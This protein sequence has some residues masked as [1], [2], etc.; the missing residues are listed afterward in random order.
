MGLGVRIAG[1]GSYLPGAPVDNAVHFAHAQGAIAPEWVA[2]RSGIQSRHR[3]GPGDTVATMGTEAARRALAMAGV[4]PGQLQRL[5]LTCS[6]GGDRPG[7][8]TACVIAEQL[9]ARCSALDV[10]NGCAGFMSAFDLGARL[11]AT[12]EAPVLIVSSE[13]LTRHL[14]SPN[15]WRSWPLFGDGA[16]AVVLDRPR[17]EGEVLASLHR[18]DG[19]LWRYIFAPGLDD[20]ERAEGP[21]MRMEAH[22]RFIRDATEELLAPLVSDTLAAAGVG[23]A[24]LAWAAPHQPN[25]AWIDRLCERMGL[26]VALVPRLVER[27]GNVPSAMVPLGLDALWRRPQPPPSGSLGIL[28]SVGIGASAGAAVLRVD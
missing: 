6:H 21:W 7:P 16:A 23:A 17:G 13:A 1:T 14:V 25:A 12:G 8:A 26:P 28:V 27:T 9:G 10:N 3:A 19:R 18:S 11:V 20:P 2:Q 24:D 5:M 22:G 4:A 15:D